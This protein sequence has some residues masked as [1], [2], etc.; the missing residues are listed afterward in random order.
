M[1]LKGLEKA[2]KKLSK[3]IKAEDAIIDAITA[4][5]DNKNFTSVG[6]GGLPNKD[7]KVQL[8]AGYMDGDTGFFG[9]VG[10]LE[11]I[12]NP[13]KVAKALSKEKYNNFLVGQGAYEYAIRNGFETR[14]NET[15]DSLKKYEEKLNETT[16]LK[17]YDGH[18]TVCFVLKDKDGQIVTGTST[19]GLF[20]KENGRVGD[21]P[22]PGSGYYVDSFIG[23]AC[24]T[25]LGEDIIKCVLSYELINRLENGMSPMAAAQ[26]CV[27]D[28]SKRLKEKQG[29]ASN[30]S[31][32]C[33]DKDG[34]YGV[35][36]NCKFAFTY[37][38]D[39]KKATTYIVEP[40]YGTNIL[41]E[42]GSFDTDVD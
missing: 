35:G 30:M 9:A 5:E 3:G 41:R 19:S 1:S 23:G 34:N 32:I 11:G 40:K 37:A 28:M 29:Y 16:D 2:S 13:I 12:K 4:I 42:A 7:G 22:I 27:D 18:D 10:C 25:G 39:E 38:S 20:M 26:S 6:Y 14:K 24:A 31:I 15:K 36:T 8:D 17:A 33:L 21:S